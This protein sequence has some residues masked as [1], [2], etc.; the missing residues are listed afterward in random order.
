M[1]EETGEQEYEND[2]EDARFDVTVE[3]GPS[4]SSKRKAT[5]R[6][7][8]GMV[9]ITDDPDTKQVLG[10]MAMMNMEGEGIQD[11]RDYFR[12]KLIKLG[13]IKPT[14]E[15]AE[16]LQKELANQPEDPNAT[17]LQAEARKADALA[18]KAQ[19]DTG[20]TVAKTEESKAATVKTLAE[21][22]EL[23]HESIRRSVEAL[24]AAF[25]ETTPI[26]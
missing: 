22:E 25:Q 24:G 1:N 26:V 4:S 9:Q 12:Q 8:T 3:V 14:D 2:L 18:V 10:A 5:V 13:V 7:L 15:E 21:A 11:V 19:A 6:A 17:F 23:G 16:E 20:L